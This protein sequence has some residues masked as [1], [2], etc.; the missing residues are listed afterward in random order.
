LL[1]IVSYNEQAAL[2]F[3]QEHENISLKKHNK[4]NKGKAVST[5]YP[6][7]LLLDLLERPTFVEN[8]SLMEQLMSLIQ[9]ICRALPALIKP[10]EK[11][12]EKSKPG[13]NNTN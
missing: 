2:Y 11:P 7:V 9:L 4:K 5:K 12:E 10:A 3:L 6:I 8:A 13:S 1:H